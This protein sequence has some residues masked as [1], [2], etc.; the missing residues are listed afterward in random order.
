MLEH[1]TSSYS[2][3]S[4]RFGNFLLHRRSDGAEAYFEGDDALLWRSNIDAIVKIDQANGWGS[5]NS[6]DKSFDFLCG[7]YDDVL[8][9]T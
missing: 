5:N 3:H 7:G 2:L 4:D 8:K 9:V 6:F 1:E